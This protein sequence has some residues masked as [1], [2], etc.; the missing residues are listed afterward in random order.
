VEG[1]RYQYGFALDARAVCGEWLLSFPAGRRRTLFERNGQEFSFS[2]FLGGEKRR[3]ETL[4][5]PNSLFISAAAQN[6]HPQLEPLYHWFSRYLRYATPD[7]LA[8]RVAFTS[9][10]FAQ[11]R[12]LVERIREL[13]RYA[14]LGILDV[15]L[16]AE[17]QAERG[18]G[19]LER[20]LRFRHAAAGEPADFP[21]EDES[22]GTREW[23]ALLGPVVDALTVGG[24]LVADELDA[25]LHPDLTVALLG[26]FQDPTLNPAGAQL[27]FTTHD[28][29]LLHP[30]HQWHLRRDQV[31]L[32]EKSPEGASTLVALSDFRPRGDANLERQ[33]LAGRF[34]GLPLLSSARLELLRQDLRAEERAAAERALEE[35]EEP[36]VG[37]AQT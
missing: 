37:A 9:R 29:G 7:G 30:L 19:G 36:R 23:F 24:C 13:V 27:V 14:D 26:L 18:K 31:W 12:T 33:Y 6:N 15:R 1:V 5:R 34:G 22:D 35:A 16:E 17:E 32:A 11:Q 25:S 10:L 2:R 3:L 4:T 20:R 8:R 21:L 28:T